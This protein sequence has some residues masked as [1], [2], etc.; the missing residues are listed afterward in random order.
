MHKK[1]FSKLVLNFIV[2]KIYLFFL[3]FIAHKKYLIE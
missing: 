1:L 2:P 3:Y